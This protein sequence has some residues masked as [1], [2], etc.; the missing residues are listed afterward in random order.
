MYGKGLITGLG[1]AFGKMF[2]KK[3]TE[4][5]PEVH[6]RLPERSHGSLQ[7]N[8]EKC[9]ACGLCA[10]ACPNGTIKVEQGQDGNGKKVLA[11]YKMNMGYCLYCG[12]CVEACPRSAITFST[13]FE[14]SV[15][16]K[17]DCIIC[18]KGVTAV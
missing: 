4:L 10:M 9:N 11:N 15:F 3:V 5:Y 8:A 1:I 17:D 13:D 18:W 6:P 12:Y 2:K 14:K 7:F 16:S